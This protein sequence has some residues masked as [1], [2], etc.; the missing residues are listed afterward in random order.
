LL[1]TFATSY[2]VHPLFSFRTSSILYSERLNFFVKNIRHQLLLTSVVFIPNI[3]HFTFRTSELFCYEHPPPAI[4]YIR[5]FHSEHPPLFVS[6]IRHFMLR[7]S[8]ILYF[9]LPVFS[10]RT[11]DL[12]HNNWVAKRTSM[13]DVRKE[14]RGRKGATPQF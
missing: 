2:Y 8:G 10:F 4:T 9:E 7:T 12:F 3:Q 5:C 1:R 14:K 6:N 13:S 11:S